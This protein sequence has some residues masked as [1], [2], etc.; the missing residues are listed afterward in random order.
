MTDKKPKDY[1]MGEAAYN[2]F[3]QQQPQVFFDDLAYDY[4]MRW[5]SVGREVV[6]VHDRFKHK[7]KSSEEQ[8][9]EWREQKRRQYARKKGAN[10]L[11]KKSD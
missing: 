9:T 11:P 6:L 7:K 3:Y 10:D 2:A 5:V 1:L 8:R 4:Q